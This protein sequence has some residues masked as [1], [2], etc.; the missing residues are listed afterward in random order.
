MFHDINVVENFVVVCYTLK[1]NMLM[2]IEF[3]ESDVRVGW[4]APL[5]GDVH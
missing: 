1:N 5:E 4:G 3:E 2:E